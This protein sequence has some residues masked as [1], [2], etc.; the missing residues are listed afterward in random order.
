MNS[1]GGPIPEP[2]QNNAVEHLADAHQ[3]LKSLQQQLAQHP[4]LDEAIRKI[5]LALS[6][7]TLQTGG[8]L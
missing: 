6:A 7:L 4:E 1:S 3:L 8:L 2:S 5:E